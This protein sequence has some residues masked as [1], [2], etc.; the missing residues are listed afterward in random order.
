MLSNI[1][2]VS[3]SKN[4]S[5]G[6]LLTLPPFFTYGKDENTCISLHDVALPTNANITLKTNG[7]EY[8]T[9]YNFSDGNDSFPSYISLCHFFCRIFVFST[10]SSKRESYTISASDCAGATPSGSDGVKWQ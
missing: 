8:L 10:E 1:S 3:F 4:G 7:E 5:P 2:D 9:N 6:F